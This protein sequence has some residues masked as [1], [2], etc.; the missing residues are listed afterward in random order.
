M[1][2][3]DVHA[4]GVG[5]QTQLFFLTILVGLRDALLQP[6]DQRARAVA[7]LFGLL[8]ELR[9]VEQ[10][11]QATFAIGLCK[12]CGGSALGNAFDQREHTTPLP[13]FTPC[14]EMRSMVVP[15]LIL[16]IQCGNFAQRSAKQA[17]R[18][19]ATQA[20]WI[21]AVESAQDR[22]QLARLVAR[23]YARAADHDAGHATREQRAASR[24]PDDAR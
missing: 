22:E 18:Q 23:E 10:I 20:C 3:D 24:W 12:Q 9:E 7:F 15:R 2:G 5:L 13:Q 11:G 6:V 19:Y 16:D 4:S 14:S 21:E 17:C 8:H 1:H